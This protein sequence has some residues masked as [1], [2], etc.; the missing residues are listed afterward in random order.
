M[1]KPNKALAG[2]CSVTGESL[3]QELAWLA[4]V[5]MGTRGSWVQVQRGELQ[6][7][8]KGSLRVTEKGTAD[9]ACWKPKYQLLLEAK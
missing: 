3:K 1:Q 9:R 4:F 6:N 2:L 5:L 8:V 7:Q